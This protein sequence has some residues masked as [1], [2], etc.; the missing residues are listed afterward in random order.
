MKEMTDLYELSGDPI[1]KR[2]MVFPIGIWKTAK[3]PE[4]PL[5]E[6]IADNI[7]NNFDNKV[8]GAT[9]PFIDS[10]GKHDESSPAAGWIKSVYKDKWEGGQ[11]LFADVEWTDIGE[12]SIKNKRYK[13]LSPVIASHTIPE[14]GEKVPNVLRS[15]SLTNVPV[16]RMM[17]S[18]ELADGEDSYSIALS[19]LTPFE[20]SETA[21]EAATTPP[22]APAGKVGPPP[23]D[24]NQE[25][26]P[27]EAAPGEEPPAQLAPEEL[28]GIITTAVQKL[29]VAL[30]GK[31]GTPAMR[32]FFKEAMAKAAI[33]ASLSE[34]DIEVVTAMADELR[35]DGKERNMKEVAK[36]FG[37]TEDASEA[38]VIEAA[39]ILKNEVEALKEAQTTLE[40]QLT[41]VSEDRDTARTELSEL[42]AKEQSTRVELLLSEAIAQNRILPADAGDSDNPGWLRTLAEKD[43]ETFETVLAAKQTKVVDL[44]EESSGGETPPVDETKNASQRLAVA[45]KKIASERGLKFAEAL[46]VAL[47]E[48]EVLRADYAD[49]RK[50][51]SKR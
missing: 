17:P 1:T 39:E 37:L 45:A 3:Y 46:N 21:I 49:W 7:I 51:T 38:S 28:I 22:K 12:D 2:V 41:E 34:E 36:Y 19:E 10:S 4:L 47:S 50:E 30:K 27:D 40:T 15:M 29:A 42:S 48:D 16:L 9:E 14:T 23:Q 8:L 13:Y 32:S 31:T 6:E 33:H 11:A 18:I 5:T 25:P 24:A 20:P 35:V 44:S 26:A 43:F